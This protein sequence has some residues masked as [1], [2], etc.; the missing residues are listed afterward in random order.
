VRTDRLLS[1]LAAGII[2]AWGLPLLLLGFAPSFGALDYNPEFDA[3]AAPM[4]LLLVYVGLW[5]LK[6]THPAMPWLGAPGMTQ[7]C[8]ASWIGFFAIST[9]LAAIGALLG[10]RN[11]DLGFEAVS[12]VVAV[13]IPFGLAI[14]IQR[15][16]R[17]HDEDDRAFH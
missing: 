8:A 16:R 3:L 9:T 17:P 10:R 11:F 7:G 15:L 5:I 1:Y 6:L 4:G 14:L 12:W 13:V 2:I